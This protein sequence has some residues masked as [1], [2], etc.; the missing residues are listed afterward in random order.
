MEI[1]T[2]NVEV[3]LALEEILLDFIQLV[4]MFMVVVVTINRYKRQ[5]IGDRG[6]SNV[7]ARMENL[8][9]MISRGDIVCV[10]QL[11]MDRNTFGIL[12][13][14]ILTISQLQDTRHVTVEEQ[15]AMFLHIL[16][17]HVKNRV[18]KFR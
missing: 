15:V 8:D 9:R 7:I 3:F 5:V 6:I 1:S 17:H 13:T 12:C 11:R 4:S 18:I 16:A 10:D 2:E 14:L